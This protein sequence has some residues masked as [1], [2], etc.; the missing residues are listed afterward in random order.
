MCQMGYNGAPWMPGTS[1][2]A[3]QCQGTPNWIMYT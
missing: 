3:N 1:T 2:A